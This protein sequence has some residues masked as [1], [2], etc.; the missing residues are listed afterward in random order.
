MD[1]ET[2]EDAAVT[3]RSEGEPAA[4]RAA[5][6]LMLGSFLPADRYE[7]WTEE[8]RGELRRLDLDLL[9]ELADIYEKRGEYTAA[10]EALRRVTA[11]EPACED[12]HAA[13]MRLYGSRDIGPRL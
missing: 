10:I 7:Q 11:E 5:L 2:F 12:A 3:A 13:L 1:V 8:K 6:E 9:V 4:Y